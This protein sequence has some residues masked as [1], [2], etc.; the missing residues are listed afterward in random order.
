M[1]VNVHHYPY[2]VQITFKFQVFLEEKNKQTK[3]N[4]VTGFILG[5]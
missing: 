5:I 4:E 2:W 3:P 1:M